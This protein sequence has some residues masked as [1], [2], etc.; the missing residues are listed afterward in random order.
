MGKYEKNIKEIQERLDEILGIGH[1]L[2]SFGKG[3]LG[4]KYS[5]ED[6]ESEPIKVKTTSHVQTSNISNADLYKIGDNYAEEISDD[7]LPFFFFEREEAETKSSGKN[8]FVSNKERALK[9]NSSIEWIYKGSW[10]AKRLSLSGT[11]KKYSKG[12]IKGRL[13]NFVGEWESGTFMGIISNGIITGGQIVDG[14]YIANSDGFKISPWDFKSGGCSVGTGFVMGLRMA[15]ENTK[16]KKLSIIQVAEGLQIKIVDNNDVEHLLRID[17]GV[18]YESL[19]MK[20]NGVEV[21]WEN[22][23]RTKSDFENSYIQIGKVFSIPG[24]IDINKGVQYIEVKTSEYESKEGEEIAEP[25]KESKPNKFDIKTKRK[26]WKPG[27][28]GYYV[29]ELE[30]DEELFKS[31]NKFKE[32]I[33]SGMFFKYLNFFKRLVEE[34]RI[35]GYGE[36]PSLAFMYPKEK[37]EA[38]K[39]KDSERDKVMSYFSRF[40]QDVINNFKSDNITQYY[41]NLLKKEISGEKENK[42]KTKTKPTPGKLPPHIAALQKK[43]LTENDSQMSIVKILKKII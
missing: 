30:D 18:D 26:G 28:K 41:L 29:L 25:K 31:V 22:Y 32:D 9:V 40:R 33:N 15:K 39:N 4:Q 27:G 8:V 6:K 2:K 21:S 3:L 7:L 1:A 10:S 16:H 20:I 12:G 13:I 17:K 43:Y 14:Y 35:D 24:V 19:D 37:G 38:F 5:L 42:T 34:G 23:N 11:A 36:Y